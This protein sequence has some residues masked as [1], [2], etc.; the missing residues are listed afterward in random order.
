MEKGPSTFAQYWTS[1]ISEVK[2]FKDHGK[3]M[4]FDKIVEYSRAAVEFVKNHMI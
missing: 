2:H 3:Q 1:E 4:G